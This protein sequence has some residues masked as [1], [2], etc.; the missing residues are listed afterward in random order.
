[1]VLFSSIDEVKID[2]EG[3]YYVDGGIEIAAVH[4]ARNLLI[5]CRHL[6]L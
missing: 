4:D 1:M 2:G 6:M 5:E 3:A